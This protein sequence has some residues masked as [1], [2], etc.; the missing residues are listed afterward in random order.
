MYRIRLDDININWLHGSK[1]SIYAFMACKAKYI[2]VNQLK[3]H[4]YQVC[5]LVSLFVC[6]LVCKLLFG[7]PKQIKVNKL[8]LL[9]SLV[10]FFK[11]VMSVTTFFGKQEI[12]MLVMNSMDA[13]Y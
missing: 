3:I 12:N 6:L 8:R 4:T 1:S 9:L 5:L 2:L 10:F 7:Q 11:H 13:G